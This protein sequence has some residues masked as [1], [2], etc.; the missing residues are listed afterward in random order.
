QH[1]H[2][3]A[4][5][6]A[7]VRERLLM[8]AAAPDATLVM[9]PASE[10]GLKIS[11]ERL[12]CFLLWLTGA[13][14]AIVF[15]EPSPYEVVS[16][17]TLA[18]FVIGGLTLSVRLMPLIVLLVLINIGYSISG[19]TVLDDEGI[20]MWLVTSWYLAITAIFF[21]AMLGANTQQRL[22]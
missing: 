4:G 8:I 6:A 19:W 11:T 9:A 7:E 2:E 18:M 10:P 12:R 13:S 22:D 20:A 1:P 3:D 5:G 17:L 21:A 14:G 16:F 15:I